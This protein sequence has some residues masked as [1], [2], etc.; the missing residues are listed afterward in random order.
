MRC[1]GFQSR[2][3]IVGPVSSRRASLSERQCLLRGA[4]SGKNADREG[5]AGISSAPGN[6]GAARAKLE[7][8]RPGCLGAA[9]AIRSAIERMAIADRGDD[10]PLDSDIAF[11]VAVLRASR[12]RFYAQLT[13]FATTALRFSIRTTNR[14]KGV[15][16]ASVADHKKG[17]RRHHRRPASG[18]N[19]L[20]PEWSLAGA[21]AGECHASVTC[22]F[23]NC[24][25]CSQSRGPTQHAGCR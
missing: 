1:L 16:L 3:T 13:G 10:D 7:S 2:V 12:N 5:P 15:Q 17:C 20:S 14:Y 19:F 11:H 18:R 22:G 9:A 24:S 4:R 6:L 21:T 23:S 25:V 8:T